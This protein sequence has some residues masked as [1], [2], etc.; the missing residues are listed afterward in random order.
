MPAQILLDVI[1]EPSYSSEAQSQ[2]WN[3]GIQSSIFKVP[4]LLGLNN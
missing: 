1:S 4:M 2:D 3:L